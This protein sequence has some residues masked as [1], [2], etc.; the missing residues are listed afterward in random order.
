ML[1]RE[2]DE[3]V[4]RIDSCLVLDDAGVEE[5]HDVNILWDVVER[6]AADVT[7]ATRENAGTAG[8]S[9]DQDGKNRCLPLGRG[10][11]STD[12]L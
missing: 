10:Q 7:L 5:H 3:T 11:E 8:R 6:F 1:L 4:H 12:V 2:F 9:D